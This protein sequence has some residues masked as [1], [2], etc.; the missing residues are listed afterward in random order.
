MTPCCLSIFCSMQC[1][2][3]WKQKISLIWATDFSPTLF[4][5]SI[6]TFSKFWP[7]CFSCSCLE[8]KGRLTTQ[9]VI[10]QAISTIHQ[11]EMWREVD[12]CPGSCKLWQKS[13]LSLLQAT[14]WKQWMYQLSLRLK[15]PREVPKVKKKKNPGFQTEY[16]C[17]NKKIE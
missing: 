8:K 11:W 4:C 6:K 5:F 7:D 9:F 17:I 15:N 3:I 13:R 10:W 12:Q 16:H 2:W 14:H 1:I